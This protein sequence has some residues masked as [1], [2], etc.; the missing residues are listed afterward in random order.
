MP[1]HFEGIVNSSGLC[2]YE[3]MGFRFPKRGEYFLSGAI[4]AAYR[5]PNDIS[6]KYHIVRPTYSA[7]PV[8]YYERGELQIKS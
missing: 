7:V 5:A 3:H 1:I 2:F 8:R 4:V 6:T